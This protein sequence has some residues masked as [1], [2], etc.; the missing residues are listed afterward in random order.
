[1]AARREKPLEDFRERN[2]NVFLNFGL[3]CYGSLDEIEK[4][5]ELIYTGRINVKIIY[6]TVTAERLRLVKIKHI[7]EDAR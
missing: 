1:M 2:R 7:E 4:L 6:E 5:Q 3:I